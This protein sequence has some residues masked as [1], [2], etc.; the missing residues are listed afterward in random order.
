MSEIDERRKWLRASYQQHAA[1]VNDSMSESDV[2]AKLIDP[3]FNKALGWPE[4]CIR[5]EVHDDNDHFWDYLFEDVH[6]YFIVEAKRTSEAFTFPGPS[7]GKTYVLSSLFRS[8][9]KFKEAATQA[10]RYCQD[11]ELLIPYAV[12]TNG[13]Q[14]A[15]FRAQRSDRGWLQGSTLTFGSPSDLVDRFDELWKLLSY[16]AVKAGSLAVFFSH[17]DE[18]PR[19]YTAVNATLPNAD[20]VLLRNRLGGAMIPVL[21]AVFDELTDDRNRE[22]LDSCYVYSSNLQSVADNFVLA[23]KDLP[24]SYLKGTAHQVKTDAMGAGAFEASVR[25]IAEHKR[26]STVLLLL[27]GIGAGKTTFL[28]RMRTKYCAKAID[29]G[30]AYYYIDFRDAPQTPPFEDFVFQSLRAQLNA[31]PTFQELCHAA[32]PELRPEQLPLHAASMLKWLFDT[33]LRELE[34]LAA[35]VGVTDAT[36]IGNRKFARLAEL[37]RNNREVVRRAFC[38]LHSN[39]RFI[40]LALDNADQL[41]IAYQLEIFLFAENI[42]SDLEV[43]VIAALRE[44]KYYLASQQGAFN[45]FQNQI[46]HI[47]SPRLSDLLSLRLRYTRDHLRSL[48][49]NASGSELDDVGDFLE[50]VRI[51]GVGEF[52]RPGSSNVVRLLERVSMGDMRSALRMFRTFVSSGNTRID[53]ILKISRENRS[54]RHPYHVPFHEF[55]KSVMLGD[56]RYYSEK[57]S[58]VLNL[59]SLSGYAPGS[60]FT[61]LR[62]LTYLMLASNRTSAQFERGY[63]EVGE[64]LDAFATIPS[65][66]QEA[67]PHLQ[68]LLKALLIEA[69]T[70]VADLDRC[71]ALRATPSGEYYMTFLVKAFAYVD[72]VWID[73][74]ICDLAVMTRLRELR[75]A[76]DRQARFERVDAFLGYLKG[77]EE[78]ERATQMS[79]ESIPAFQRWLMP[80]IIEQIE[81][82]KDVIAENFARYH[83]RH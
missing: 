40:L 70:G 18:T 30:G 69:D 13:L 50:A 64:I 36:E 9:K 3:I 68:R 35:E 80:P 19:Q 15:V 5:R 73:T 66:A 1:L 2:R 31:D 7:I 74:P 12:V 53:K 39:E 63:V 52:G 33:D 25:R 67:R 81:I 42:A 38:L 41:D 61:S 60:H 55:T 51:G 57:H 43:N 6:P 46:F 44:E 28:R 8:D 16:P 10:A 37:T 75:D 26:R 22:V 83:N 34:E 49:P 20:E 4:A 71:R 27:G 23:V 14:L 56:H 21:K 77:E 11:S 76:R 79:L 47:S 24:P 58:S 48:M 29:E 32:V 59:F 45:A 65:G 17:P 78:R 72:L 62:I 54:A 82:E